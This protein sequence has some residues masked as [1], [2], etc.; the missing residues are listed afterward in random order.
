MESI[1]FSILFVLGFS[2]VGGLVGASFFQKLRI[3]QVVGFVVIGLIVGDNGLKLI[4]HTDV[5][6]LQPFTLFALGI[7]G[8]LVGCDFTF[9]I[10][11]SIMAS[12]YL[13]GVPVVCRRR[14]TMREI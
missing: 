14:N 3:P 12:H 2:I 9:A 5:T 6:A 1:S 10:G 8:F 7:I 11:Q 4:K 13:A